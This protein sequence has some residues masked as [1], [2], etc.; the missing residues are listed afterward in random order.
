M[1]LENLTSKNSQI[2]CGAVSKCEDKI[3]MMMSKQSKPGH[4]KFE[5][6]IKRTSLI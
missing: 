2:A 4:E 3:I 6:M 5:L 1:N